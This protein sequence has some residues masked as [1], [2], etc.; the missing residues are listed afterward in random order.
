MRD[1]FSWA[2]SVATRRCALAEHRINPSDGIT[3]R[4]T[5]RTNRPASCRERLLSSDYAS[6][7]MTWFPPVHRSV[8]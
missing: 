2:A 3:A 1:K 5:N 4:R 7:V 8:N 6:G